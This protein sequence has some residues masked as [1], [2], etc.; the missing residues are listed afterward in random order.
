MGL[1][2]TAIL[3]WFGWRGML[4]TNFPGMAE[5]TLVGAVGS[6]GGGETDLAKRSG[7]SLVLDIL[8]ERPSFC[9][10]E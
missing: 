8:A 1:Q 3:K 4:W 7:K 6:L 5:T 10:Q 2:H 9:F